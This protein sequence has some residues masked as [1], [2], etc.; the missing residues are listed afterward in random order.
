MLEGVLFLYS[1]GYYSG[2]IGN[3][4][5]QWEQ[6]GFFTYV[7]PFLLIFAVVFGVLQKLKVFGQGQNNQGEKGINAIIAIVVGLIAVNIEFVPRF[8][9]EIFPQL[10]VGLAIMLVAVILLEFF[11]SWTTKE[12][13]DRDNWT[14]FVYFGI[15]AIIFLVILNNLSDDFGFGFYW[16]NEYWPLIIGA[17]FV[18]AII[19]IVV[20]G[21][22]KTSHAGKPRE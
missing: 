15:G 4:F 22:D 7:L 2:A 11:L 17:I 1:Y 13:N 12:M 8:F 14:R 6:A 19:G 20:G 16:W 5:S 10:G 18:I 21:K 9:S 3:V